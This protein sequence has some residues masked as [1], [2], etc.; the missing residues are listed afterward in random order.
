[1]RTI[2]IETKAH[3]T[4]EMAREIE[5]ISTLIMDGYLSGDGWEMRGEDEDE[6][7]EPIPKDESDDEL[8][9]PRD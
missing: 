2:K 5:H 4:E 6:V 1:M 9:E 8:L 3:N 7:I